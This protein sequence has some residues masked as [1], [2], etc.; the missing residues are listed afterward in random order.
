ML[1]LLNI[2][3]NIGLEEL[4]QY[5]T[6]DSL[7]LY[8]EFTEEFDLAPSSITYPWLYTMTDDD[9]EEDQDDDIIDFSKDILSTQPKEDNRMLLFIK[10]FDPESQEIQ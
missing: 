6:G 8:V 1:L 9:D 5:M 4:M 10:R 3:V 2:G 7:S